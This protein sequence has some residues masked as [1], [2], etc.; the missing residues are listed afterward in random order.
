MAYHVKALM[1]RSH[2][3]KKRTLPVIYW[4]NKD[5]KFYTP[6]S[7]PF[8]SVT[9]RGEGDP[10]LRWSSKI[11][12]I[13]KR[14]CDALAYLGPQNVKVQSTACGARGRRSRRPKENRACVQEGQNADRHR[15]SRQRRRRHVIASSVCRKRAGGSFG[16]IVR[17]QS[18]CVRDPPPRLTSDR[19]GAGIGQERPPTWP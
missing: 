3:Q 19:D 13:W 4:A 10:T 7:S 14:T 12:T 1:R 16:P 15:R 6:S 11:P 9:H 17:T 5:V 18:V 8:P 2:R